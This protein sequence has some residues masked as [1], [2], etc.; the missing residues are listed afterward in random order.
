MSDRSEQMVGESSELYCYGHPDTPTRLRCSRC[1]RPICGRCAIPASVGQ[2]CPECVAEARRSAP[3]VRPALQRNAPTTYAILIVNV[4]FFIA[5]LV[6]N[7]RLTLSL[8]LFPPA[9]ASGE[10]W[11]LLT[12]M[13]LH[14]GFLHI[15]LNSWVLYIFGPQVEQAFGTPRF[16]AVYL[17]GGFTGSA[18]SYAFSPPG[19]LGVGA[20]GAIF[21]IVG[22]LLVFLYR[23]RAS[24]LMSGYLRQILFFV[25]INLL[26]GQVVGGIDNF[27]HLGGLAGGLLLGL[28]LDRPG[29][30]AVRAGDRPPADA[31]IAWGAIVAVAALGIALVVWRT[32]QLAPL[33]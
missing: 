15:A 21:A 1:D 7:D 9:I 10:W 6:T 26:F 24:V 30:V 29:A 14:G 19:I 20:S 31:A 32:S 18:A 8:G 13:V 27:A 23:R 5:Q 4:A 16:T 11:R 22:A 12:P 17:V 25:G 3:K 33:L 28:A 2:H